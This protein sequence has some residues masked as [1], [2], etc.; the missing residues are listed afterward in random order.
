MTK[1]IFILSSISS[2]VEFYSKNHASPNAN[3]ELNIF[4]K[5]AFFGEISNSW[6]NDLFGT[7]V[8]K[9]LKSC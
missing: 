2:G 9:T 3:S 5:I 8:Y 4:K 1:V 6:P 7:N